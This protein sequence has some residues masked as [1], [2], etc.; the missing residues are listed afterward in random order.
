[1]PSLECFQLGTQPCSYSSGQE[2]ESDSWPS[3]ADMANDV[4]LFV[5]EPAEYEWEQLIRDNQDRYEEERDETLKMDEMDE[6]ERSELGWL[7]LAQQENREVPIVL[8]AK[9]ILVVTKHVLDPTLSWVVHQLPYRHFSQYNNPTP[10]LLQ[11]T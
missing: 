10:P 7:V 1:M 6:E 9:D 2:E 11:S 3:N 5:S 8:S 4:L